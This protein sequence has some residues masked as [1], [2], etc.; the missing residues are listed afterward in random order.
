MKNIFIKI[1]ILCLISIYSYSFE[2]KL[3]F[4]VLISNN[5]ESFDFTEVK[6]EYIRGEKASAIFLV[7]GFNVDKFNK[8]NLSSKIRVLTILSNIKKS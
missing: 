2:N 4:T 6:R 8:V 5:V 7:S 3:N 1:I